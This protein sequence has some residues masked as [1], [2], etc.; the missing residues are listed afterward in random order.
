MNH[1]AIIIIFLV[2]IIGLTGII[3]YSQ[4]WEWSDV[5]TWLKTTTERSQE[6]C[7]TR[8]LD[9]GYTRGECL[10]GG[11]AEEY[12]NVC[13]TGVNITNQENPV[14]GCDFREIEVWD[15]CCCY[16]TE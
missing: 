12:A 6:T 7:Q 13:S 5:T 10:A 8:C 2:A 3:F 11:S 9:L 16:K 1:R 14:P 4:G 15:V